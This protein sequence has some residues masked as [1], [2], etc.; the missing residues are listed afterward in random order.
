MENKITFRA[1]ELTLEGLFDQRSGDKGVV[2]LHPHPLYGGEM[3][4]P[5]V[6]SLSS[7]YNRR[8][9]SSLRFNFRGVGGSEGRYD[10]GNG[11]RDDVL[12]AISFMSSKGITKIH[13]AG[14]SFGS[15]VQANL[16][17]L[18][19]EVTTQ[20]MVSPPIALMPLPDNITMP[21]LRLVITGEHD[22][23][24]PVHLVKEGV[25]NWNTQSDFK[26]VHGADH[27]YFGCFKTLEKFVS[28]LLAK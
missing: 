6:E 22:E 7:T 23:I 26:V 12:A 13:L 9:W 5:V 19:E 14:Y 1:A 15:W 25:K 24:A 16:P 3:G 2:V 27:F 17:Q 21:R 4:N 28:D 11:E 8:G 10:N 20:I 18:P